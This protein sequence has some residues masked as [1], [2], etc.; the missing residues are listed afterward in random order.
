[1]KPIKKEKGF[2]L[3][4]LLVVLAIIGVL[5]SLAVGGIRI[6]QEVNR[7]TQRKVLGRDIQLIIESYNER[8]NRYPMCVRVN[9]GSDGMDIDVFETDSCNGSQDGGVSKAG[10]VVNSSVTHG[11]GG[12]D[13]WG[14]D[15]IPDQNSGEFHY[16]YMG[17]GKSYELWIRLERSNEPHDAGTS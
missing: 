1:M 3:L 10:F 12:S 9:E 15:P 6:V 5:V 17:E 8:Y 7:D 14:D 2:T 13:H 4:E 11:C 16:C